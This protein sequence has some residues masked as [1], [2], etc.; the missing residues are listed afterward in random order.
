MGGSLTAT[1]LRRVIVINT[2]AL[3]HKANQHQLTDADL[4][5]IQAAGLRLVCKPARTVNEIL[6][7][8]EKRRN[9]Q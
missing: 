5:N 6:A 8:Q 3:T 7:Q 1:K 9:K 2:Q 4:K